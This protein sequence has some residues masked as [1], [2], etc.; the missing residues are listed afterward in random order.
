[1]DD[2]SCHICHQKKKSVT[3]IVRDPTRIFEDKYV[4]I[5]NK[6]NLHS[7]MNIYDDCKQK[8]GCSVAK[9]NCFTQLQNG[10]DLWTGRQKRWKRDQVDVRQRLAE[11]DVA[12]EGMSGAKRWVERHAADEPHDVGQL[13]EVL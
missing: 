9:I 4:N 10:L 12:H 2:P 6:K 1:M 8:L 13:G 11:E 3:K 5:T 7:K